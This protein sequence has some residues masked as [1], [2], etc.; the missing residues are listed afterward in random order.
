MLKF[1]CKRCEEKEEE[2]NKLYSIISDLRSE[3]D[4][5]KTENNINVKKLEELDKM[6]ISLRFVNFS[7]LNDEIKK[8]KN[9]NMLLNKNAGKFIEWQKKGKPKLKLDIDLIKEL[10]SKGYSNIEIAK[11][12]NVSSKTIY[13]R[14]KS[15]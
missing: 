9:E 7:K 4:S 10:K 5:L 13:N 12:F 15:N 6:E 2:I 14:L 3:L 11:K 8:L 1:S